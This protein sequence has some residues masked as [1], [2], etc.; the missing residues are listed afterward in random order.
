MGR[1]LSTTEPHSAVLVLSSE[2][3]DK[4]IE[5]DTELL[6]VAQDRHA[7][8]GERWTLSK[9]EE[10]LARHAGT[11]C[12]RHLMTRTRTGGQVAAQGCR[13]GQR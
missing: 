13:Q 8:I 5:S 7:R 12:A 10:T 11:R 6:A 4:P 2:L 3:L 1:S 9:H